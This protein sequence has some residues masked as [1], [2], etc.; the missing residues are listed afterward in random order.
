MEILFG[1][2]PFTSLSFSAL[3]QNKIGIHSIIE[4]TNIDNANAE[5]FQWDLSQFP[6]GLIMIVIIIFFFEAREALASVS[7]HMVD[8]FSVHSLAP[9]PPMMHRTDP[10]LGGWVGDDVIDGTL[11]PEVTSSSMRVTSGGT[12][13]LLTSLPGGT[14]IW[15]IPLQNWWSRRAMSTPAWHIWYIS[16]IYLDDLYEKLFPKYIGIPDIVRFDRLNS[17]WC[18]ILLCECV[19]KWHYD[20][21]GPYHLII[22]LIDYT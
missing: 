17:E 12:L 4:V 5:R 9:N 6:I 11:D 14:L 8:Y 3:F 21:I 7:R 18:F 1:F 10:T 13:K 2:P 22:R 15:M 16:I 19:L 20:E